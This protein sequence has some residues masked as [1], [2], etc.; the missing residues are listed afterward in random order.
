MASVPYVMYQQCRDGTVI[1]VDQKGS[2]T[3]TIIAAAAATAD[4][5]TVRVCSQYCGIVPSGR[6]LPFF[7][8]ETGALGA[9]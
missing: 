1:S 6:F 9:M 4:G 2:E 3:I 5:T 7:W 8:L